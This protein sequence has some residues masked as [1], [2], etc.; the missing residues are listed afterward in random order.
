MVAVLERYSET[1]LWS[2]YTPV[3]EAEG[4]DEVCDRAGESDGDAL[5]AGMR[6]ELSGIARSLVVAGWHHFAGHLDV[7]AE[8]DEREAVIGVSAL[9][10]EE[11]FAE[12]DGEYFDTNAAELGD[13]EVPE[14][15]NEDHDT[16]DDGKLK[17]GR[18]SR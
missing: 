18:E 3:T 15:V 8:R 7:P 11:A 4:E 16:E 2:M 5:P 1:S 12:A 10:A 6:G 13:G 17:D 9:D 14:L